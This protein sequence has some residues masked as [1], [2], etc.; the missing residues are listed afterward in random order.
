M[1]LS[2]V[3]GTLNSTE[4]QSEFVKK[5]FLKLGVLSPK[6]KAHV[7]KIQIRVRFVCSLKVSVSK[8]M[9]TCLVYS[10]AD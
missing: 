6:K 7:N 2:L 10:A 8:L 5:S 1:L 3:T 4:T 9:I